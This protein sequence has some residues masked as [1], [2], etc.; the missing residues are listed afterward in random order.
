LL[1]VYQTLNYLVLGDLDAARVE[2]LQIDLDV[3]RLDP[4]TGRA[5]HG[6]DAFARYLSGLVFEARGEWS[7][8]MIAYRKALA[9]YDGWQMEVPAG[10]GDS[11]VR[12][13]DHL[14]IMDER[15]RYQARFGIEHWVPVTGG[16]RAGELIIV[17]HRGLAPFKY[18]ASVPV[19]DPGTGQLY[20]LSLP[21]LRLRTPRSATFHARVGGRQVQ[22]QSVERVSASARRTL[23]AEMPGLIGRAISRNMA[24]RRMTKE[25]GRDNDLL[26]VMVNIAGFVAEQADTRS[27]RTLPDHIQLAR[28]PLPPGEYEV[29]LTLDNGT[30]QAIDR[31]AYSRI[32]LRSNEKAFLSWHPIAP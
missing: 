17:L 11:L 21:Q 25:A 29:E 9:A 12:L 28:I 23:D 7:D 32:A 27:W 14:G 26:G 15:D 30:G 4:E 24:K 3:R 16:E 6:G 18:E 10:L 2:V 1:H 8:A 19:L 13:A 31:R 22:G 20:R 5:P